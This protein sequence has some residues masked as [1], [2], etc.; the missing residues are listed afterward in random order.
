MEKTLLAVDDEK[1][2]LMILDFVFGKKYKVVQK[3]NGE[4]AME[5][6]QKGNMPDVIVADMNMPE[7]NGFEFIL[8][9]RSSGLYR[10]V[11]L[12]MLSGNENTA[13]KI[14]CLNA[15]ADDYLVKPFNPEELEARINNIFRRMNR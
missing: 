15:G 5:W 6:L 10:D 14:K 8:Q 11:P 13:D 9:I 1:S 2:I 12:I 7:M 3:T 4:E